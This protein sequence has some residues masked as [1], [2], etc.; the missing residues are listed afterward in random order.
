MLFPCGL[1]SHSLFLDHLTLMHKDWLIRIL[2]DF[3]FSC[4]LANKD[5]GSQQMLFVNCSHKIIHI[6]LKI[7]Q[8]EFRLS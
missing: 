8:Q 3:F 6:A 7:S 2:M 4:Y 5:L 1:I